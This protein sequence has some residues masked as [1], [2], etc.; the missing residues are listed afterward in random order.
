MED[1]DPTTGQGKSSGSNR[2]RIHN[3]ANEDLNNWFAL[4]I[5]KLPYSDAIQ[6]FV[7]VPTAQCYHM[8]QEHFSIYSS[9]ASDRD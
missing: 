7:P 1:L 8:S 3:T 2:I 9:S 5:L 4:V 6:L